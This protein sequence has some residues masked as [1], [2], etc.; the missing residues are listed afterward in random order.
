M[1]IF[2]ILVASAYAEM[3][4]TKP[5]VMEEEGLVFQPK[6]L[7]ALNEEYIQLSLMMKVKQ[8]KIIS[9]KDRCSNLCTDE[10]IRASM[11]E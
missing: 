5:I 9:Y 11:Y 1:M 8:P 4:L 10:K 2:W 3:D 6:G 7:V